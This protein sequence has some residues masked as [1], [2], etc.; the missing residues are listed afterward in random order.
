MEGLAYSAP[1]GLRAPRASVPSRGARIVKYLAIAMLWLGPAL[2]LAQAPDAGD[3]DT[4]SNENPARPLQMP[5]ASTEVKE[6]LEDFARFQRR[7]AWERAL[8]ALDAIPEEQTG[9]FVDGDHGFIIPVARK[10][11]LALNALPPE[12][13]AAYRLFH[14]AA[15]QKLFEE[16][17]GAA[18][19]KNLERLYS[20]YFLTAVGD[21]AA[22]RLGDLYFEQGRFDRAADCWLAILRDRPDTDLS[23]AMLAVKAALALARAGRRAEFAQVRSELVERY[24]DEQITLG[25]QTAAPA[26]LL[27]RLLDD[28]PAAA[29]TE[30]PKPAPRADEAE[31]DLSGPTEAAWQV[32]FAESVEAGMTPT[33]LNQWE[34]NP[35]SAAVPAAVVQG[36]RLF[37]NYLGYVFAVNLANGKVLWRS[38]PFHHLKLVA[39]QQSAQMV[40]PGRFAIVAADQYV[41]T[42]ARDMKDP[43]FFAP[44]QLAC[45]RAESGAVVWQSKDL[46]DYAPYDLVGPP[47]LAAGKLF[48]AAKSQANPQQQHGQPQQ[49]VLAIQPHDGKV[50]WTTEI[51]TFRQ[52]QPFWFWG[53]VRD[54]AVQP[55]LVY[56]AG[57][58]YLDTHQGVLA[59]LDADS[60]VLDW[61]FAYKTDPFP[62]SPRFFYYG[63]IQEPTAACSPPLA[64]GEGFLIKGMQSDRLYALDPSRMKT[65]W[66]RP[67]TKG[68]RLLGADDQTLF[69]GGAE[70]SALD[71]KTKDLV[72]ATRVPNGS[73]ENR[74]LV[75]RSG[76]WQLT[77]R[78]IYQ[79][80]PKSGAVRRIV[81][82]QDLGAVGGDL[83]L[84]D[85]GLLAVSNRAISAYPGRSA[86]AQATVR[87]DSATPRERAS[88]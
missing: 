52:G 70:L 2:V 41:W 83:Y 65:L 38:E 77:P 19:L 76:L 47:L 35:L 75:R 28:E 80:D 50:L 78:G 51:G 49:L 81:R 32:R 24:N 60:G 31:P 84:T 72:W 79:I 57:A 43:N 66:E 33:E 25:G 7:G 13:K 62:F 39:A 86:A 9:R 64:N 69:L 63:Q 36:A 15:A 23:P 67:I 87:E 16:A 12:G 56:R 37:V 22:D 44:F 20:A 45:R 58:V 17:E 42:L 5:P 40:D 61:G 82:G 1:A 10:R 14:D 68:A 18:E 73:W 3:E 27:G 11:R 29:E 46:S 8:K 55:Q 21:N 88:R 30:W 6:A 54:Q 48:I 59:R 53:N 85:L 74:G 26:E 4:V 71:L 34:S